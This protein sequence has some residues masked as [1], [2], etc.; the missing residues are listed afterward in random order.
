MTRAAPSR[1]VVTFPQQRRVSSD[2]DRDAFSRENEAAVFT[3][4]QTGPR[5]E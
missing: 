4:A 3:E 5:V 1:A 2:A